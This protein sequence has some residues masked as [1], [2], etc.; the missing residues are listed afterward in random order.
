MSN[1]GWLISF[2]KLVS[3][4]YIYVRWK[5]MVSG[6]AEKRTKFYWN[7]KGIF[8]WTFTEL[9]KGSLWTSSIYYFL[10]FLTQTWFQKLITLTKA[11]K[12]T[13]RFDFVLCSWCIPCVITFC[14]QGA[15]SGR[16]WWQDSVLR[17][18]YSWR[19]HGF[20][21]CNSVKII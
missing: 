7:C 8:I 2:N 16:L 1:A 20:R 5:N 18:E 21:R 9:S 11:A 17:T 12:K 3:Y 10:S 4:A 6:I 19:N 15:S 13:I 14:H